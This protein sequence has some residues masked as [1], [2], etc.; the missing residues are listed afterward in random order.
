MKILCQSLFL[1][2]SRHTGHLMFVIEAIGN[3]FQQGLHTTCPHLFDINSV[4]FAF[5]SCSE[6]Y[7]SIK[8]TLA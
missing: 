5:N 4:S 2:E 7:G 6:S 3:R 8:I 1:E